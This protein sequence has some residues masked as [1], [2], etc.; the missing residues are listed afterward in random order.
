M[1]PARRGVWSRFPPDRRVHAAFLRQRRNP[2]S[3]RSN[4]G[5]EQE[6]HASN[7]RLVNDCASTRLGV[8]SRS[9]HRTTQA[10]QRDRVGVGLVVIALVATAQVFYFTAGPGRP[11]PPRRHARRR[12]DRARQHRRRPRSRARRGP[13]L[14]RRADAQRRHPRHRARWRRRTAGRIVA[15]RLRRSG[16]YDGITC[17]RLSTP[18]A[19]SIQCGSLDGTGAGDPDYATARSRTHPPTA[20]TRPAPSPWPAR[21]RRVQQRAPV[22]HRLQRHHH[23]CRHRRRL[24]H[25]RHRHPGLDALQSEIVAGGIVD[26]AQD[27]APVIATTITGFTLQ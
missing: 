7:A 25:R 13:H 26:D 11:S 14:D 8:G 24:Q 2:R 1:T 4:G 18:R 6:A 15:R 27:G 23:S 17:H 21:R 5:I 22:L 16:Y 20:S 3:S 12:G 9:H 19:A 10:R